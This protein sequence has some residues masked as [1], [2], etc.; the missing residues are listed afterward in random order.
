MC[1]GEK[2]AGRSNF[3]MLRED[4]LNRENGDRHF[5]IILPRG[6][7]SSQIKDV[8]HVIASQAD[9]A[10]RDPLCSSQ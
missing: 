5:R 3:H 1:S 7:I 8:G 6:M 4:E 2:A 10:E 9:R